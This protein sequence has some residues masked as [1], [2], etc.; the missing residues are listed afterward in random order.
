[1]QTWKER[2]LAH[3]DE[4][5]FF[6]ELQEENPFKIRAFRN[7]HEIIEEIDEET[8]K[9]EVLDGSLVERKGI[10]KGLMATATSFLESESSPE[11]ES[12]KADFPTSLLELRDVSGLGPKKIKKI[13]HDLAIASLGELEYACIE[14]RLIKLEG[15]GEK[16][17]TKILQEI[18]KLKNRRHKYLLPD[19]VH[20]GEEITDKFPRN[21]EF[22]A[23]GDLGMRR[24]IVDEFKYLVLY[25]TE[26]PQLKIVGAEPDQEPSPKQKRVREA[27]EKK[28][29]QFRTKEGAPCR[30][31][32][33]KYEERFTYSVYGTS[34]EE[35][36]K[37]LVQ[38]A[39]KKSLLLTPESLEVLNTK[40]Q[41]PE[42]RIE[43]KSEEDLYQALGLPFHLPEQ[44]EWPADLE[45]EKALHPD[46]ILGAFHAH[47]QASDGKNST[48]EMAEAA[49]KLG[50]SYLGISDHSKTA[51]YA[52]G[53]DD[54]RVRHQWKEIEQVQKQLKNF[55]IFKGVES[56]IL[57][58]GD[59]DYP[60]KILKGFDFVIASI[61]QRY[62]L[63][64]MTERLLACIR[65]PLTSMI[66][67]ISG[68]LLL[69]REAYDFDR[70]RIIEECIRRQVIM[71]F[72]A[73][74]HRLDMDWRD[75]YTARKDGLLV[76]IN[77]DA[78][79]KEGLVDI[80]YG[81]NFLR[82]AHFPKA[83]IINTWSAEA[84]AQFFEK[85]KKKAA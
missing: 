55:R 5:A 37:S 7:A 15:F 26:R 83:Q 13:F 35:H 81:I 58:N 45:L 40:T 14:N 9:K 28:E 6:L 36:W 41:K 74:P 51:F 1:M 44:R 39:K 68:R 48:L 60:E 30:F 59:L 33:R 64:D 63:K 50:W 62:G 70:T 73:N 49:Q 19:A 22:E 52:N 42:H 38:R 21:V 31:I 27:V 47:T 23:L 66:G 3:L 53:L 72:N 11:W 71:E 12:A 65:H 57:K 61:H 46:E 84:I 10:G 75:L 77:P 67:H 85:R 17:Q 16:T 78:H 20:I 24:E 43:F 25:K 29:I 76:S 2:L 56:D 69:S 80:E 54:E 82:K 8:L 79:S 4:I 18:Q 32:F 34:S